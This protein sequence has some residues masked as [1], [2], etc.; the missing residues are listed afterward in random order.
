MPYLNILNTAAPFFLQVVRSNG[1]HVLNKII[2]VGKSLDNQDYKT[3]SLTIFHEG[4]IN[5][6]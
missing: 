6:H 4:T 1:E 2:K 5:V 3:L